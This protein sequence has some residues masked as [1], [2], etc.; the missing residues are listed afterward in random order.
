MTGPPMPTVYPRNDDPR[1]R[2]YVHK[3]VPS[4][5]IYPQCIAGV[6]I[7][8]SRKSLAVDSDTIDKAL[9][10]LTKLMLRLDKESEENKEGTERDKENS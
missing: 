5:R 9:D 6:Q 3:T 4:R 7:D 8:M 1:S 10:E 2:E